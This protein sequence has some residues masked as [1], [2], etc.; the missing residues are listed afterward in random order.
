MVEA[1]TPLVP[2]AADCLE[3]SY[4]RERASGANFVDPGSIPG[5][6]TPWHGSVPAR[7]RTARPVPG[8]ALQGMCGSNPHRA[9]SH[10]LTFTHEAQP[11]ERRIPNPLVG[12]S[13][14]PV[15]AAPPARA[16]GDER[17]NATVTLFAELPAPI[18]G[19]V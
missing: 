5:G 2:K 17:S 4:A 3:F 18:G 8:N 10:F 6:S 11:V 16:L 9:P 12:S 14:L 7:E 1:P 19:V 13:T 15:C